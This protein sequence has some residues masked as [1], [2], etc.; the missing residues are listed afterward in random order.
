VL[1]ELLTGQLPFTTADRMELVHA[2][3]ARRPVPPGELAEVPEALGGL[4][5]KLLSKA[6]EERYQSAATRA[7]RA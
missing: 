1:Y 7:P 4:V 3:I 2:H 5:M 6:A